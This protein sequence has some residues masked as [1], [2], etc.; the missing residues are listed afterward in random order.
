AGGEFACG[1]S[2]CQNRARS[3]L[4]WCGP[5][6]YGQI[7]RF[8]LQSSKVVL[9]RLPGYRGWQ[10]A[11]VGKTAGRRIGKYARL[12]QDPPVSA[13]D[14]SKSNELLTVEYF[15]DSAQC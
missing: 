9:A 13:H 7:D 5:F 1:R 6:D 4:V 12:G 14:G 2:D 8:D 15:Y 11:P 10:N 3:R